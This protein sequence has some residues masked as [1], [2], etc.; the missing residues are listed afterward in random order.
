MLCQVPSASR[1][2]S[3]GT[4]AYGGTSAGITCE[5]PWPGAAVPVPPPVVGRQQVPER[6]EQVVVAAGAGLEDRD[7]GGGV[8]HEQVQQAVAAVRDVRRAVAGE[9]EDDLPAPVR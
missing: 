7:P 5:R 1:P 4:V 8:R 9:V 3:T 6:G 2:S